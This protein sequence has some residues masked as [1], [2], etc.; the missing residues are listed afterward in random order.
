MPQLDPTTFS[1]QLVWLAI[2]FVALY[3][4]MTRLGLPRVSA[5]LEARRRRISGDLERAAQLKAEAEGV[6]QAY[7]RALAEAHAAAQATL[8]ETVERMN[9]A[10]SERQH[11]LAAELAAETEAAERR[12][13]EAKN[14]ALAG[15]RD[16]AAEVARAAAQKVAG[17]ELDPGRAAAVVDAVLRE[18]A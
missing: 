16:A 6:T 3:L 15:L 2:T 12:I 14:A 8:R 4:L 18:R 5:I 9:A 11:A 7:E 13:L 17:I 1:T 10:A